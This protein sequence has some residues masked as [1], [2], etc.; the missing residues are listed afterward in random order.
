MNENDHEDL[1]PLH[2]VRVNDVRNIIESNGYIEGSACLSFIERERI[3][4]R[5]EKKL[6]DR[7]KCTPRSVYI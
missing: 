6:I 7:E 4:R 3:K 5:E 1:V 2:D